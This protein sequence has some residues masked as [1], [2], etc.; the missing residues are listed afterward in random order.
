MSETD[1]MH[2]IRLKTSDKGFRLQRNQVGTIKVADCNCKSN[3]RYIT[4]GLGVGSSDLVGWRV[5][6]ITPD[7]V[8][9]KFA[10]FAA[11]EVKDYLEPHFQGK[12][13][14]EERKRFEQQKSFINAI[15][16]QGGIAFF[17][18]D[19]TEIPDETPRP[20]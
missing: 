20:Y 7:M 13:N 3:T 15:N 19:T 2:R 17:A 8:G 5:I 9:K 16:A 12:G 10:Q 6:T 4:T 14:S 11:C 18:D 1:V